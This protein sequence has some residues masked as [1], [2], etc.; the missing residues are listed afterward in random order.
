MLAATFV[1][2]SAAGAQQR[3]QVIRVPLTTFVSC[4]Q[5]P[6]AED[7]Y[8]H[9]ALR[10]E[11][12]ALMRGPYGTVLGHD[13]FLRPAPLS[14]YVLGDSALAYASRYERDERRGARLAL[15]GVAALFHS[16][17]LFR[18]QCQA[19]GCPHADVK[20]RGELFLVGGVG[21][22]GAGL[23][24]IHSGTRAAL[25]ALSLSNALLPHRGS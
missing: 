2:V 8:D 3:T 22:T 18:Q 14:R 23:H 24:Y 15:F 17:S 1:Q 7:A 20:L 10:Y 21:L 6:P 5:Q 25:R 11:H 9:C 19:P 4:D 13:K 16:V 12:H